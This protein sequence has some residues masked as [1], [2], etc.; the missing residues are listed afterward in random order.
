MLTDA[1]L[2]FVPAGSP[3]SLVGASGATF[4]STNT[5]DLLGNGVGQAPTSI[6][7]SERSTFGMD[8]GVGGLRPELMVAVG[9]AF[10]AGV[11][12]TL[13]KIALQGAADSGSGGGYQPGTWYDIVSQDGIAP[14]NLT[15][16]AVPFRA[17]W[18]PDFPAGLQPRFLRLLF[19]PMSVTA[20]PAG[21]FSAGTIAFALVTTVRDD[22]A[23]KY[24]PKNYTVS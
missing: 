20:L 11:A 16:G 7:G 3:L 19:S 22:Y 5:I 18:L 6:I 4:P 10:V 9:T 13:L 15:A 12:G 21:D 17:S 8:P 14:S 1:L 23:I 2:S 24:A